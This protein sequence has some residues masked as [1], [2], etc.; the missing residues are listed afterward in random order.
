VAA[1]M[2]AATSGI[3]YMLMDG[4]SLSMPGQVILSML[5]VGIVGKIMDDILQRLQKKL[6][7]Y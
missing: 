7:Y 6:T 4:R 5:V 1:E 3:G 2:I